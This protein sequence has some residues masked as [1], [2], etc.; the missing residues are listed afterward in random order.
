VIPITPAAAMRRHS[1]PTKEVWES[2]MIEAL[3][4]GLLALAIGLPALIVATI[5]GSK[6]A[7]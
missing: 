3:T 6:L 5:L 4:F 2:V 1:D 7:F